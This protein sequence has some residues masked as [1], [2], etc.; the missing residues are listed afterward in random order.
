M[1]EVNK[2]LLI[3]LVVMLVAASLL[4]IQSTCAQS[5][6]EPSAPEF[7]AKLIHSD[8]ENQSA[9]KTIELAIKN[10]PSVSFYNVR[11]RANGGDWHL[12]YPNNS[13]LPAKSN[14]KYTILSYPSG[15]LGLEYQFHLGYIAQNLS[16]GDEVDFQ[17]Q[18]MIGSIHRVFNAS[19]TNQLDMYPYIFTGEVSEWS[20]TQTIIIPANT[21]PN[22]SPTV[23]ELPWSVLLSLCLLGPFAALLLR[24]IRQ[25]TA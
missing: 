12:L 21:S 5:I 19:A 22:P 7:T 11:M 10:Q 8:H 1:V 20:N 17:V 23:P 25:L 14:G 9:N 2:F 3:L 13:S 16:T 18:A 4:A 15:H 6:S 24:R